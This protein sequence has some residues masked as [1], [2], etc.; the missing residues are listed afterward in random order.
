MGMFR[1]QKSV[2]IY[3]YHNTQYQHFVHILFLS[4]NLPANAEW[5]KTN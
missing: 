2:K 3:D 4:Q 1:T 5:R